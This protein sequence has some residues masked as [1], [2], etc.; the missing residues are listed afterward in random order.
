MLENRNNQEGAKVERLQAEF[1]TLN[2]Q[3]SEYEKNLEEV[4]RNFAL[5]ETALCQLQ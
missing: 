4:K 2:E 3:N 1:D 5:H